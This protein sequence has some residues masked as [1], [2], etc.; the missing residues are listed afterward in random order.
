MAKKVTASAK[1]AQENNLD[2]LVPVEFIKEHNGYA[3]GLVRRVDP[4]SAEA[5]V[6][7]KAAK[8][9]GDTA[10]DPAPETDDPATITPSE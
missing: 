9:V 6:K 4:R 5:L 1:S 8:R 10:P 7:A 3:K 2:G